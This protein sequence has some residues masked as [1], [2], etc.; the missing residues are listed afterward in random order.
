MGRLTSVNAGVVRQQAATTGETTLVGN[1]GLG[2]GQVSRRGRTNTLLAV[3]TLAV[4]VW[5]AGCS[6]S[7]AI[8]PEGQAEPTGRQGQLVRVWGP[9]LNWGTMAAI[10]L[11]GV[12]IHMPSQTGNHQ[13]C[14]FR[15]INANNNGWAAAAG[16]EGVG[17]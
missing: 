17:G 15:R 3:A 5:A 14:P 7:R 9:C 11:C 2:Y 13:R 4:A 1:N 16:R 10:N 8:K 12:P 6:Q